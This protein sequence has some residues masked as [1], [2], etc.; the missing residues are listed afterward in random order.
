MSKNPLAQLSEQGQSVWLDNLARPMITG[1]ALERLIR[2]DLVT[3]VTSNPAIFKNA[4]TSSD[5]YNE[6]IQKLAERGKPALEI[7]EALAIQDI[8]GA[9]DILRPVYQRTQGADGFVS[10]EVS[11]HLARDAQGTIDEATRLW[12]AVDRPNVLIKIPGTDEC[13]SAVTECLRRGIN[14]NITLLFA[15]DAHRKMIEAYFRALEARLENKQS[16]RDIASVASFFLSRIDVKVDQA[17]DAMIEFGSDKAE[18]A[19][20]VRG[21]TAITNAKLAYQ[22][23]K[24]LHQG[25]RWQK[26][27]AAGARLQRPLWASTSTKDPGES[28]V[29]YVESLIGPHTINT[30]PDETVDAFRDHGRVARTLEQNL[31]DARRHFDRLAALGINIDQVTAE[32]VDEGI[33]KFIK[34]FDALLE[35]LEEKRKLLTK[36]GP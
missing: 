26:L 34:P 29:K 16:V 31:D 4:M 27:E 20:A 6:Q 5:A 1:G 15:L 28:D 14:V 30:M 3:G 12:S 22:M 8:R 32:L 25:G 35:A 2:E 7:Y 36:S 18:E 21:R 9:A 11:P 13:V 10:L 19:R 33:D 17:L 24:E 23:W